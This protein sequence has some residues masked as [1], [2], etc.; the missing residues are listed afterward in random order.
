MLEINEKQYLPLA[1]KAVK[2][3]ALTAYPGFF[4]ED[5]LQDLISDVVVRMLVSGERYDS[6]LGSVSTWVGTIARNM[7]LDAAR[8]ESRRRRVYFSI[9]LG[10]RV[11]DDGDI[12][13]LD[14]SAAD[15]TDARVIA[16][17][18]ARALR[19][20]LTSERDRRL[21]NDMILGYDASE[22]AAREGVKSGTI[23]TAVCHLRR[24]LRSVA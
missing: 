18:T 1:E 5:D 13:G 6:R 19:D 3:F 12:V 21:L 10:G 24:K 9:P 8:K 15:E 22:M 16:I 20:A 7:V 17:D 23:Y 14:P 2:S 11:D 4:T